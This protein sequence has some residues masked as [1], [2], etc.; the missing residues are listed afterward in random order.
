MFTVLGMLS[1]IWPP[2]P[3]SIVL[4]V[5]WLPLRVPPLRVQTDGGVRVRMAVFGSQMHPNPG[6]QDLFYSD[7]FHGQGSR[8]RD[9]SEL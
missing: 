8:G 4:R 5:W 6:A 1:A 7:H 3:K 2:L 9:V